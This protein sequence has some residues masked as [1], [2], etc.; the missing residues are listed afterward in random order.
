[1][2]LYMIFLKIA[3]SFAELLY[4]H[5]AIF[6]SQMKQTAQQ[7]TDK[8]VERYCTYFGARANSEDI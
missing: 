8:N 1:M 5:N 3:I 6:C 4:S 7:K 2:T